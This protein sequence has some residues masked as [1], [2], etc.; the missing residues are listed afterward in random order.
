MYRFAFSLAVISLIALN[1]VSQEVTARMLLENKV[2]AGSDEK[3]D[4]AM[5]VISDHIRAIVEAVR[6]LRP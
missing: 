4:I 3:K 2:K 1:S 6:R 5:R